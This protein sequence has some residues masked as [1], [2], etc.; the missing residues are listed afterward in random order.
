MLRRPLLDAIEND[1]PV[2]PVLLIDEIDRADDEFEAFLLEL[3]S[4]FQVTIPEIGTIRAAERPLVIL[5]SNRTRELH[6]ALRRRCVYHWIGYPTVDRE[7]AIVQARLPDVPERLAVQAA[8][9][10][11]ELRGLELAKSPGVAETLDWVQALA[12]LDQPELEPERGRR[13]PGHGAQVPRGP[14]AGARARARRARRGRPAR[15]RAMSP[16]RGEALVRKLALF[17]R[18]LRSAGAEVGPGRLQ[19]AVRALEVVDLRSRDEVY[20]A[21]RCT[22]VSH[23][24]DLDAFDAA[25]AAFWE[26]TAPL[27]DDEATPGLPT[28]SESG[29]EGGDASPDRTAPAQERTLLVSAADEEGDELGEQEPGGM[30][31]SASERLRELDFA[32]YS[33]T[34]LRV[35]R[36]LMERV[37]R[38]APMRASRRLEVAHDGRRLDKRR[39]MRASMRTEGVPLARQWRRRRLVPR[40]LLFLIDVSGSMEPYARALTMF[41]QAAVRDGGKVEAFTFGTRLTHVTRELRGH[42][43]DRALRSAARVVPDWAGGTRI[44]DNLKTLNDRWAPRGMTRGAVVVIASDGW[45]RGRGRAPARGD[46]PAAPRRAHDRVGQPAGRRRRLQAARAGHV[47]GAAARRP[48]PARPQPALARGPGRGARGAAGSGP[49]VGVHVEVGGLDAVI[50][51]APPWPRSR[52]RR[53]G[54]RRP[55]RRPRSACDCS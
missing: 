46:D 51:V 20:W 34:E 11:A 43:P 23:Q 14:R 55:S 6:D 1:D 37:A 30:A 32:E 24:K 16:E 19:D 5:T 53:P 44:G 25:F 3:L 39:T 35:A 17:G 33:P 54:G 28:P 47:G 42:D 4:D 18:V 45:E 40:K 41:L 7:V 13:H 21:L 36:G 31:W 10:V 49:Q 9:F 48:L 29:D 38:A 12:S 22:L 52:P 50:Q 27:P 2:P 8:R 15:R 26:R